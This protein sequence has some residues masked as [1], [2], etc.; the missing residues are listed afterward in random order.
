MPFEVGNKLGVGG[1]R[2]NS[3]RPTDLQK[4][5]LRRL[6]DKCVSEEDWEKILEIAVVKAQAGDIGY[7]KLI[8]GYEF[9]TP[10]QRQEVVDLSDDELKAAVTGEVESSDVDTDT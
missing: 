5:K 6:L 4:Q 9:G 1:P 3:G 10:V 7:S 8:L 2:P